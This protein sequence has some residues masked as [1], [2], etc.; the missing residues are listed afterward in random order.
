MKKYSLFS[1]LLIVICFLISCKA[2]TIHPDRGVA[3][4][5]YVSAEYFGY[6]IISDTTYTLIKEEGSDYIEVSGFYDASTNRRIKSADKAWALM[7]DSLTYLNLRYSQVF[8]NKEVFALLD[9]T[10]EI[11]ALFLD[12]ETTEK[13]LLGS[14]ESNVLPALLFGGVAGSIGQAGAFS[15]NRMGANWEDVNGASHKILITNTNY[16]EEKNRQ[17]L[18]N[19]TAELLTRSNFNVLLGTSIKREL[20]DEFSFEEAVQEI[21]KVNRTQ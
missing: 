7:I 8:Q 14:D 21:H 13:I 1:F 3:I 9:I 2:L 15:G 18:K 19:T 12:H 17:G 5:Y 10:G 16:L 4:Q 6:N 11:C 20:I